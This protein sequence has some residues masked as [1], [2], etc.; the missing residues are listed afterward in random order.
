MSDLIICQANNRLT[1]NTH[2]YTANTHMHT[3]RFLCR[4]IDSDKS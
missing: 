4:A 1:P 3:Q 2:K